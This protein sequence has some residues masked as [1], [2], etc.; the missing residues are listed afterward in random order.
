M[1]KLALCVALATVLAACGGDD[2][3]V[4]VTEGMS[5]AEVEQI[6]GEPTA[7]VDLVD[8]ATGTTVIG[9]KATYEGGSWVIFEDDK[10][11]GY[12]IGGYTGPP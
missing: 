6:L 9:F 11:T 10:V 2:G 7:T 4:V 3:P 8:P 1:R 5:P 12:I